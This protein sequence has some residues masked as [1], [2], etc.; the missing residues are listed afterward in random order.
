VF[1][2]VLIGF[3]SSQRGFAILL[4][5]SL[6]HLFIWSS[7]ISILFILS[8]YLLIYCYGILRLA[9]YRLLIIEIDEA[10]SNTSTIE[11]SRAITIYVC[12]MLTEQEIGE[13]FDIDRTF[14]V[15]LAC[16]VYLSVPL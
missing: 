5:L 10:K 4:V 1:H 2:K 16:T 8:V 7:V 3:K 12:S 11:T 6:C 15:P 13:S 14:F 9:A